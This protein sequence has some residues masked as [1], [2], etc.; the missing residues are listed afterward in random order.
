MMKNLLY[1]L[2]L[3]CLFVISCSKDE[4]GE[5]IVLQQQNVE[6]K[7]EL[8]QEVDSEERGCKYLKDAGDFYSR[9]QN[10]YMRAIYES[11]ICQTDNSSTPRDHWRW[12][13]VIGENRP[14]L[15]LQ[16]LSQCASAFITYLNPSC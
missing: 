5:A 1:L 4:I 3:S 11:T 9:N 2:I 16:I 7:V 6:N 13:S 8:S 14:I 15:Q 10:F 12:P